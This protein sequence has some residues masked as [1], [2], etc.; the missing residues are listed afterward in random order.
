MQS[1]AII[2]L[3]S[4]T[5]RLVALAFEPERRFQMVDELRQ[6]VRLSEGMGEERR[7]RPEPF[8]RA[9]D[10]LRTFRSYCDA[11]QVQHV[12]ATATSAVRVAVNGAEFVEAARERAGIELRVLSGEEEAGAGVLAVAN[13]M[14]FTD[15]TVFDLG[16]GSM[17]VS[18]MRDRRYQE[19]HAY[20]LGAVRT[21]EEYLTSDP[22]KPKQVKALTRAVRRAL[23]DD[24]ARLPRGVP[25]VGMGGTLRN[26]ANVVQQADGYAPPLLHGYRLKRSR[27]AG[28]VDD[29]VGMPVEARR[30]VAGLNR[31]RADIIVAGSLVIRTLLELLDA[32]EV[33]ISG[34][35]LREG[36][37]YPYLF[38][39]DD[40]L[41]RDVG[42]F[43]VWNLEREYH[44]H[45]EHDG[46]VRDLAL[47]LFDELRPRH[48]YGE[49]ERRLLAA[50]AV[51][52][53]IGMAIDYYAHHK[54]GMY[55]VMGRPLSG[56]DH[57]EQAII[58]LLV[59]YHRRGAPS[60]QGLGAVL[61]AGD[62]QRVRVLA[63]ILRMAEYF[64]RAKSQRI[65]ALRCAD[66]LAAT[67][68]IEASSRTEAHVEVQMAQLR[69]DLLADALGVPI[70]V[71]PAEVPV[72]TP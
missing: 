26:L 13:S 24:L 5:A 56:F 71:V 39:R 68:R 35:G 16:G 20:P 44:D 58:A 70:E 21:T 30:V 37:F 55:L 12:H 48:G 11:A 23:E 50:A 46:H 2:D 34:Q 4:N 18:A 43:S 59:R 38:P 62:M 53:D 36:L 69:S 60:E 22:P 17:Q 25:V 61:E 67:L 42:A 33:I 6:L 63:G 27:L 72:A 28:L 29:L 57:R 14:P 7:I 8:E 49:G 47:R 66:P 65:E 19:G 40:H 41:A 31:D 1:V 3:G 51:V 52:H 45:P 54:H 64:D 10:A 15:A 32:D 9:I